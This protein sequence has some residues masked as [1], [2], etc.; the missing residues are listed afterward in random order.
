MSIRLKGVSNKGGETTIRIISQR[1]LITKFSPSP[2]SIPPWG[3]DYRKTR[4]KGGRGEN[5]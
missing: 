4:K 1:H 3:G 2:K 5:S